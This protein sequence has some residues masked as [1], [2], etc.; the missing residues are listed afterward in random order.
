MDLLGIVRVVLRHKIVSAVVVLATVVG[1]VGYYVKAPSTWQAS[2]TYALVGANPP[3]AD[4]IAKNPALGELNS[5]NPYLALGD[6]TTVVSVFSAVMSSNQLRDE[7]RQNGGDANGY[8]VAPSDQFNSAGKLIQINT[9]GHTPGDALNTAQVVDKVLI[10][11]LQQLQKVN[12]ADDR[13]LITALP[14]TVADSATES[15]SGKLRSVIMLMIGGM[16]ALFVALSVAEA[17]RLKLEERRGKR[18]SPS[19]GDGER[20]R[21]RGSRSTPPQSSTDPAPEDYPRSIKSARG[22]LPDVG[23]ED[24]ANERI[25]TAAKRASARR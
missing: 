20:R 7:V 21:R 14:V 18:R 2:S 11:T 1:A 6:M 10:S 25:L 12:G 23:L 13:Y 5:N 19:V 22:T 15:V 3:T 16:I 8:T 9:K 4:Q 17:I 24:V